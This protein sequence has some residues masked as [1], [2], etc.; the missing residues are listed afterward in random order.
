MSKK[1]PFTAAFAFSAHMTLAQEGTPWVPSY[2]YI[3][4]EKP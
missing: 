2:R 1:P 3:R 4:A